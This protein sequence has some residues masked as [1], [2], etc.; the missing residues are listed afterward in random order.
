MTI[1]LI[2]LRNYY[3]ILLTPHKRQF[4]AEIWCFTKGRL[5]GRKPRLFG[6][7]AFDFRKEKFFRPHRISWDV[8]G[9]RH[10]DNPDKIRPLLNMTKNILLDSQLSP[11]FISNLTTFFNDFDMNQ[12]VTVI[13]R[14]PTCAAKK[15]TTLLRRNHRY[16]ITESIEV[17]ADCAV[18][19]I[20][21]ELKAKK[22]NFNNILEKYA[23][24]LLENNRDVQDVLAVFLRGSEN[25]GKSTLV[26]KIPQNKEYWSKISNISKLPIPPEFIAVLEKRKISRLLSIQAF[27]IE[28]GLLRGVSQLVVSPTSAGKTLI[29]ELTGVPKALKGKK[30]I[31]LAPLVALAS[32]KH[33]EF[34]RHY[35]DLGLK[36]GL[37][38]GGSRILIENEMKLR[39]E[40]PVPQADIIVGTFEGLDFLLRSRP[41]QFK[42]FN[43]ATIIIDEIQTI[44]EIDRGPTLD[45]LIIRLR[46][47]FPD[48]QLLA[49]SATIG[50]PEQLAEELNLR[51]ITLPG[52][53]VPLEEHVVISLTELDKRNHLI[54]L[55][56]EE[57]NQRDPLTKKRGQTIVFT[58]SRKKAHQLASYLSHQGLRAASYHAGVSGW[59]KKRI[60][61]DFD[62]GALQVICATYALGAGVDFP[63]SQVIFE[64]ML[65][66]MDILSPN[67]FNQMLGRAG[68]LGKHSRG[69]VIFLA[70]TS[71]IT[72]SSSKTEL[73][74]VFE[75]MNAD[76]TPIEP[77][78]GQTEAEEQLLALTAALNQPSVD[79]LKESYNALLGP[80]LN[81]GEVVRSLHSRKFLEVIKRKD[82][83]KYVRLTP[84]GRATTISF[85]KPEETEN[86]L[87]YK[88]KS[89][90]IPQIALIIEPFEALYLSRRLH[91]Y[92]ERKYN[93]RFGTRFLAGTSLDVMDAALIDKQ[94]KRKKM[95]GKLDDWVYEL[96]TRWSTD[97][98]NCDCSENPYCE[99]GRL[100]INQI[101]LDL[102]LK[103]LNPREIVYA[104]RKEYE[105]TAYPGDLFKWLDTILH[106]LDGLARIW[107]AEG[108]NPKVVRD[109]IRKIENPTVIKP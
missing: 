74:I 8:G 78:Y 97:F 79:T 99:C 68:R 91:T 4:T 20:Q 22:I 52:R 48:S 38:I 72:G 90:P 94:Q 36:V 42:E 89:T 50:N 88:R 16:R 14:C 11:D 62:S 92:L 64:T 71:P 21:R 7:I 26:R 54:R 44:D 77:D 58:N 73:E 47:T 12:K 59:K 18:T 17:C 2:P 96:F 57:L 27:A 76:L 43:I 39:P 33:E 1:E 93:M 107:K 85:Y 35:K 51:L 69:R 95:D 6:E 104:L 10:P 63:A 106:R 30:M 108:E 45:G 81:F 98:F 28:K 3:A 55:V 13:E 103:G 65:M 109:L 31:Y 9:K 37:K 60:E 24:K 84:I 49:L 61:L 70:L 66:G 34:K 67:V 25:I 19:E 105:L 40:T 5:D 41:K 29:G 75:L 87:Q 102:R 53:P 32:T 15:K 80:R 82:K 83:S 23:R 101:I 86:V 100:K 56:E 46:R